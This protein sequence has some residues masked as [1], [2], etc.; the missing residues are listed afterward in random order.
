MFIR[1]GTEQMLTDQMLLLNI[2]SPNGFTQTHT[3]ACA[4]ALSLSLSLSENQHRLVHSVQLVDGA[5][6][7][8]VWTRIYMSYKDGWMRER[9][10][11]CNDGWMFLNHNAPQWCAWQT[12]NNNNKT[13]AW[14]RRWLDEVS[15]WHLATQTSP[16]WPVAILIIAVQVWTGNQS[17]TCDDNNDSNV[18]VLVL[19]LSPEFTESLQACSLDRPAASSDASVLDR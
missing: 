15:Y 16:K 14:T 10:E 13:Y 1:T 19:S 5:C 12:K 18:S 2:C 7:A 11:Y 6:V 8:Y 4:R 3:R 9:E 17:L